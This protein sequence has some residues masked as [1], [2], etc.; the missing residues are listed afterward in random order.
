MVG[1]MILACMSLPGPA[2]AARIP[3]RP[4]ATRRAGRFRF[5]DADSSGSPRQ[6]AATSHASYHGGAFPP[7][8]LL[9]DLTQG[10]TQSVGAGT[11]RRVLPI[12]LEGGMILGRSARTLQIRNPKPP[13][14]EIQ[15]S[16]SE[17]STND[18]NPKTR[19]RPW[20]GASVSVLRILD[21][22]FV[23]DFVLRISTAGRLVKMLLRTCLITGAG[24]LAMNPGPHKHTHT[25][26]LLSCA[27]SIPKQSSAPL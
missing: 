4:P 18:R 19:N 11:N 5:H 2:A 10:V 22:G 17:T 20:P 27:T 14:A 16:K 12:G 25:C 13:G 21:L 15:N 24:I 3:A 6:A 23:S 9:L 7:L 1:E 26:V 8:G